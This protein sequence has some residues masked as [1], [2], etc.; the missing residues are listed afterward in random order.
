MLFFVML[1]NGG[2]RLGGM[3]GVAALVGAALWHGFAGD[4]GLLGVG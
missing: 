1:R 2:L 3:T 4:C